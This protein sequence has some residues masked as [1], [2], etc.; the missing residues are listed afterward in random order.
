MQNQNGLDEEIVID[1]RKT[2]LAFW[3]RKELV[4]KTFSSILLFFILFTFIYPKKYE[5][6]AQLYI[7]KSNNTNLM[8]LNPYIISSLSS[9][10]GISSLLSGMSGAGLQN[11]IEIM[12]S[13]LVIDKVIKENNLRYKWGRKRGELLT[14]KDF[15]KKNISIE[16]EKGTNVVKIE[17]KSAK[18]L[19]SY[20]VVNSIINNYEK[21]NEEI[22]TKK[23]IKDKKLLESSYADTT[24]T[25][26]K[27]L[28]AM[29]NLSALPNTAMNNLGILAALKGHNRAVSSA[30]NSIQG[31]IVEGEKSQINIEQDV[32]K[33]KLV[34]SK[35]EWTKLVEQLSRDT[36]NVI[37][38]KQ[39]ELKR[40][41]EQF[42]PKL[43][44]DL[45]LGI[46]FGI[47]ASIIAVIFAESIDNKLTY[48]VLG[49][50]IIYD[51]EKNVDY[52]KLLF[53]SNP[54][55]SFSFVVFDGFNEELLKKF[56]EVNNLEIIKADINQKTI[57]GIS[58]SNKLIFAAKI[59][60]TSKNLYQQIK[61]V[62]IESK[63][64]IC[65]EIV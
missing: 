28:S 1:L 9:S 62:C 20:N 21:V 56:N 19:Q 48:N 26:N 46:I 39:P 17:Y 64:S 58:N 51:F 36:T 12:Q 37:V 42:S 45:I 38:L 25:L 53:L 41:F 57:D 5:S 43:W 2:F 3:Y 47:I 59:G 44:T 23:A 63:K 49:D 22:N 4:V 60:Q 10:D 61:N 29:K 40:N 34:K 55:E 52:L 11:E 65:K 8:E 14:T 6:T 32:D 24:D 54:K 13:P 7:N 18:P 33:L 31:Q 35:L 15:L 50:S 30:M 16:N 27:K